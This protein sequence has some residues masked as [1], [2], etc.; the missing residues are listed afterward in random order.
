[1]QRISGHKTLAM[2]L[3]YTHL[4]DAHVDDAVSKLETTYLDAITPELHPTPE[5]AIRGA[6]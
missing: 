4:S 5:H 1:M 3:R 2:V 6:A